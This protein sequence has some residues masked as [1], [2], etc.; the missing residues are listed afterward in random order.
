[1]PQTEPLIRLLDASQYTVWDEFVNRAVG[2]C[3]FHTS[4]WAAIIS[5]ILNR[6]FQ[7]LAVQK[8]EEIRGGI[9]YWPKRTANIEAITRIPLTPYQGIIFSGG[10]L[11]KPSSLIAD[12]HETTQLILKKLKEDY[13]LID[14]NLS[15]GIDDARPYLWHGFRIAPA[16]T[17]TIDL[18]DAS[19]LADQYSQALRRK[20]TL[21]KK[22]GL[23][24]VESEDSTPLIQFVFDS[25]R[26]HKTSPLLSRAQNERLIT[27]LVASG[28]AKLFYLK[29]QS[30]CAG[31]LVVFDEKNLYALMSG[32][33]TDERDNAF[34]DYLHAEV[35]IR[36]EFQG[37]RF[38]F[39]G[40]NT[41]AF[42]QFKRSFG[43]ALQLYFHANYIKKKWVRF[44]QE[45]RGAQYKI[46]RHLS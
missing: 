35:L 32:I 14:I 34:T 30:I 4:S 11:Q 6:P 9:L 23:V 36:P 25:Y 41:Q 17:Y 26:Y 39:L 42:E 28:M 5:Q 24:V 45:L 15:P 43:G 19:R 16:Y 40:A 20:I 22:K 29:H 27:M 1:M 7:I 33:D 37:K 31:L 12:S 2:G 21:S 38:D 18:Q 46:K 44:L 8:N 3:L 10:D 13:H